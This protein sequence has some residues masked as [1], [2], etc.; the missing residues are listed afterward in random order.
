MSL[1]F[2]T[3]ENVEEAILWVKAVEA[4]LEYPPF[5]YFQVLSSSIFYFP[6]K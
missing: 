6:N 5:N 4:A 3:S 1:T 2:D